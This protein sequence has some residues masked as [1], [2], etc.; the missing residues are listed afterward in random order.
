MVGSC[1]GE[2]STGAQSV[3]RTPMYALAGNCRFCPADP[4]KK[5]PTAVLN[6]LHH[7][8]G[9][10]WHKTTLK[11]DSMVPHVGT[12]ADDLSC[13]V[14]PP[15]LVHCATRSCYVVL[16]LY[17]CTVRRG[18]EADSSYSYL[19]VPVQ[20]TQNYSYDTSTVRVSRYSYVRGTWLL[21]VAFGDFGPRIVLIKPDQTVIVGE[22]SSG[23]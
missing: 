15:S 13:P 12:L 16:V 5:A 22:Q 10:N 7:C 19:L 18:A 21:L 9:P 14:Q 17:V 1:M 23:A 11:K 8:W 20:V 2:I 6:P 4:M 3:A